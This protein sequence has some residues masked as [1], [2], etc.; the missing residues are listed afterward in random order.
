MG[1]K[2]STEHQAYL[3]TL[4]AKDVS[5]NSTEAWRYVFTVPINGAPDAATALPTQTLRSLRRTRPATLAALVYNCIR[6]VDRTTALQL[7]L[8]R[9]VSSSNNRRREASAAAAIADHSSSS[10]SPLT[11]F[12]SSP[13]EE[14][15]IRDR[16]DE[17]EERQVCSLYFT[18]SA[19]ADAARDKEKARLQRDREEAAKRRAEIERLIIAAEAKASASSAAAEKAA[20]AAAEASAAASAE[21]APAEATAA[22][23]TAAATATTA[24]S[25]AAADVAAVAA[26]RAL[27]DNP[28]RLA[29]YRGAVAVPR[30]PS[31]MPSQERRAFQN[32][33]ALIA[34]VMPILL[35]DDPAAYAAVA[36]AAAAAAAVGGASTVAGPEGG[37]PSAAAFVSPYAAANGGAPFADT[38][39]QSFFFENRTCQ[40]PTASSSSPAPTAG[41]AATAASSGFL[42]SVGPSIAESIWEGSGEQ[43]FTAVGRRPLAEVLVNVLARAAFVPG[44]TVDDSQVPSE[45]SPPNMPMVDGCLVW[46]PGIGF[47]AGRGR[48]AGAGGS[49]SLGRAP[50]SWTGADWAVANRRLVMDALLVSLSGALYAADPSRL[51]PFLAIASCPTRCPLAPTLVCSLLGTVCAYSTFGS[52]PF[53]SH[54]V[55]QLEQAVFTAAELVNVMLTTQPLYPTPYNYRSAIVPGQPSNFVP[56]AAAAALSTDANG[57]TNASASASVAAAT[58]RRPALSELRAPSLAAYSALVMRHYHSAWSVLVA[59]S[60]SEVAFVLSGLR[61]LAAN[62]THCRSTRLPGTQRRMAHHDAFFV[63]LWRLVDRCPNFFEALTTESETVLPLL[64]PLLDYGLAAKDNGALFANAQIVAFTLMRLS[65][66]RDFAI[67][68]NAPLDGVHV[69]F[70]IVALGK[71]ATYA[72]LVI[73][74]MLQLLNARQQPTKAEAKA[75]AEAAAAAASS[76]AAA[77]ASSSPT[78]AGS[79]SPTNAIYRPVPT[80]IMSVHETCAIIICNI[81]PYVTSMQTSTALGLMAFFEVATRPS[82]LQLHPSY[83]S[84]LALLIEAF[85]NIVQYQYRASPT[86]LYNLCRERALVHRLHSEITAP[87]REAA[88]QRAAAAASTASPSSAAASSPPAAGVTEASTAQLGAAGAAEGSSSSAS[89]VAGGEKEKSNQQQQQQPPRLTLASDAVIPAAVRE[90]I[91]IGTLLCAVDAAEPIIVRAVA[92][93]APS[94]PDPITILSNTTL[95]GLLPAPHPIVVRKFD[96]HPTTDAWTAAVL[97]SFIFM[98]EAEM[99]D[100][101]RVRLFSLDQRV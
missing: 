56:F 12:A 15:I 65:S 52:L 6:I 98:N 92:K 96:A 55:G 27:L 46:G 61:H 68:L 66:S 69:P 79:S 7:G 80:A 93:A 84:V 18:N 57:N 91:K 87:L 53:S 70:P 36:A 47:A 88:A 43:Y 64:I 22:A 26:L 74:S 40:Q 19:D 77:A 44:F 2:G 29:R 95:V 33:L 42:G 23:A 100:P 39:L 34:R 99:G 32:A 41:A 21:G 67:L 4:L 71:T 89:A 72:D 63:L 37:A 35:E 20:A 90:R 83:P 13:L 14:N 75:A 85:A 49:F 50:A 62:R 1:Q 73:V 11:A 10:G 60:A 24:A 59:A 9:Y 97:W 78:K 8:E 94:L 45:H 81:S 17:E 51:D 58:A 25:T 5:A 16:E 86:L 82:W 31:E 30:P 28:H 48:E 101:R 38:F 76:P 3:N 54:M